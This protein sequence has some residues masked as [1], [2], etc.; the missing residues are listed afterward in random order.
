[1]LKRASAEY[2]GDRE[3]QAFKDVGVQMQILGEFYRKKQ[4]LA[5]AKELHQIQVMTVNAQRYS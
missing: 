2:C 1:M 3:V 5:L 4:R